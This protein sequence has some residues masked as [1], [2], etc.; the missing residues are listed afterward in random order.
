MTPART[1]TRTVAAASV[2]LL[3][4]A[5]G[6]APAFAHGGRIVY[7]ATVGGYQIEAHDRVITRTDGQAIL[8]GFFLRDA[9]RQLPVDG[10]EVTVTATS[11]P[12]TVGP[13]QATS[14]GNQYQVVIPD[15]GVSRWQLH[16][17]ID[18]P[19]GQVSVDHPIDGAAVGA[20]GAG[21]HDWH[22][23]V[24]WVL[25]LL[26][27][28]ALVGGEIFRV[29]RRRH[30]TGMQPAPYLPP[31]GDGPRVLLVGQDPALLPLIESV[32]TVDGYV[33]ATVADAT[34]GW[35]IAHNWRPHAIVVRTDV[36]GD[37]GT[38]SLAEHVRDDPE[39]SQTAIVAISGS[40]DA[41]AGPTARGAFDAVVA[42]PVD[43]H[44]L[45][46]EVERVLADRPRD[47][48]PASTP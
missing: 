32:L 10:A 46:G 42:R 8:Y 45:A 1:A 35:A 39:L 26:G 7:Q 20:S 40:L 2:A 17:V 23:T 4:L 48:P 15:P 14:F 34:E 18:G 9:T 30:S 21:G 24:V 41:P 13:T 3:L 11:G 29:R 44:G 25:A 6:A 27:S 37:D 36:P 28:V 47:E 33:V 12:H 19:A 22:R 43:V 31:A 16:I 5:L 38:P